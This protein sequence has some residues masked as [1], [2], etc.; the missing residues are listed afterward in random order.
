M[1]YFNL[2]LFFDCILEMKFVSEQTLAVFDKFKQLPH[3]LK[4]QHLLFKGI[5]DKNF[6]QYC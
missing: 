2:F 3:H 1:I 5:G 4:D 6:Y